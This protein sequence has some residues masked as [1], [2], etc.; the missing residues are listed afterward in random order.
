M[1]LRLVL[2]EPPE[3]DQ[4]DSDD[5]EMWEFHSSELPFDG[6]ECLCLYQRYAPK[7]NTAM[8]PIMSTTFGPELEV[9]VTDGWR[10]ATSAAV[11]DGN[12][13]SDAPTPLPRPALDAFPPLDSEARIF[14]RRLSVLAELV[15]EPS[16]F[17]A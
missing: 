7:P 16:T 5:D 8:S 11:G 15:V 2:P 14:E 6:D 13:V 4:D 17:T 1:G 12:D 9:C 10:A 3:N